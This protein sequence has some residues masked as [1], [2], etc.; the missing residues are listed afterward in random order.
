[1]FTDFAEKKNREKKQ[2]KEKNQGEKEENAI[3]G[4]L[5]TPSGTRD[6]GRTAGL[7]RAGAG[8]AQGRRRDVSPV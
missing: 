8:Q 1:M 3:G 5:K 7:T 2:K 4:A 6:G